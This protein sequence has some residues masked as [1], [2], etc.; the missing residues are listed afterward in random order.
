MRKFARKKLLQ[1]V[2]NSGGIVS[3][4]AKRLGCD[5]LTAKRRVDEDPIIATIFASEKEEMLD[6][7]ESGLLGAVQDGDLQAIKFYL[8][9]KG[10]ER[11]YTY[12][13]DSNAQLKS[14]NTFIFKIE[15]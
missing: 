6:M 8:M 4:V 15:D 3:T 2:T 11:G 9:T 14:D 10:K 5:W 1:A 12:E 7:A 13:V